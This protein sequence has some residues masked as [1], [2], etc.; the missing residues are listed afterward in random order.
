MKPKHFAREVRRARHVSA[1]IKVNGHAH[2]ECQVLD[3]SKDGAKVIVDLP[4]AVPDRFALVFFQGGQISGLRSYLATRQDVGRQVRLTP[5]LWY[6]NVLA[7]YQ[8]AQVSGP[9]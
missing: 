2:S 4:S 6:Y 7:N 9:K 5:A 1:W 3:I 8:H